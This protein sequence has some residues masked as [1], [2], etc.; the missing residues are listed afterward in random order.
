MYNALGCQA[1]RAARAR[2]AQRA[3]LLAST[4]VYRARATRGAGKQADAYR[5]CRRTV[6]DARAADSSSRT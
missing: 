1:N 6:R 5:L 3:Q 2:R 4:P